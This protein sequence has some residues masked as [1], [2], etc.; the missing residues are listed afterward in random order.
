MLVDYYPIAV[1]IKA[2]RALVVGGGTVAERKTMTLL[3][4][5]ARVKVVS[6]DITSVLKRLTKSGKIRWISR[7]VSRSDL[8][9]TDIVIAATSDNKINRE[10]SQWAKSRKV[11]VNVVDKPSLS[12]FISPALL[13][14]RKAIMAVYTDGKD[15]V[16][17]RDL[18]NFLKENWDVFLSYR[19]RL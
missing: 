4:A 11:L 14:K 9:R 10:I 7:T 2:K 16:L 12:D 3:A 6:P 15:P 18:K 19:N 1:N 8:C 5:G 13:R 17:S